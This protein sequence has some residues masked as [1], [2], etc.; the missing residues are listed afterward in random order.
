MPTVT[1]GL[2]SWSSLSKHLWDLGKRPCLSELPVFHPKKEDGF[3]DSPSE[4]CSWNYAHEALSTKPSTGQTFNKEKL[5]LV[6]EMMFHLQ[7]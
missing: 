3:K 6:I 2:G 1:S 4:N 5:F 7:G